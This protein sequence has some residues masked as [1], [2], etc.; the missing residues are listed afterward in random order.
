MQDKLSQILLLQVVHTMWA[1]IGAMWYNQCNAV[2]RANIEY[3][4]G[5]RVK[6]LLFHHIPV[7]VKFWVMIV[8]AVS[9]QYVVCWTCTEWYTPQ[10]HLTS[11]ELQDD[12]HPYFACVSAFVLI[13]CPLCS[14]SSSSCATNKMFSL[15]I[16]EIAF[17]HACTAN[18][19]SLCIWGRH[20]VRSNGSSWAVNFM[21]DTRGSTKHTRAASTKTA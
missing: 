21:R 9:T 4:Q 2:T 17:W 10:Q 11:S 12:H 15:H 5:I 6:K 8:V 16:Y 13:P 3:G 20:D 14:S 7:H 1:A 18:G 19:P